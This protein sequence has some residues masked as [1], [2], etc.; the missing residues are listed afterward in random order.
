MNREIFEK[1]WEFF[2]ICIDIRVIATFGETPSACPVAY[3]TCTVHSGDCF[4][5]TTS[6]LLV[7]QVTPFGHATSHNQ[8]SHILEIS[9]KTWKI[10]NTFSSQGNIR[11]NEFFY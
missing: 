6:R 3:F 11:E 2:L 1:L 9:R 8:G 10:G 7:S 5:L 4:D